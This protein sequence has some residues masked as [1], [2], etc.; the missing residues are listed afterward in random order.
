[1]FRMSNRPISEVR[2]LF[3]LLC[4]AAVSVIPAV[5]A[6]SEP[7]EIID[8]PTAD[9]VE[10]SHYNLGFRL[11]GGGGV[12]TRMDFGVFKPINLGMSWDINQLIGPG[13]ARV[14][15]R[16][17]A[18]FF[19][20]RVLSGGLMLP[21]VA[22]GYDGQGYGAFDT[23]GLTEKDKYQF[24]EKG[25]FA[26]CTREFLIPGLIA[27]FGGNIYDFN[28]ESVY[29]FAGASYSLEDRLVLLGEYDNIHSKALNR[30]NLGA[31][32]NITDTITLEVAGR[33]LFRGP[34]S[35]RI[36]VIK[37]KGKF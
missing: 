37:Y 22:V 6:S 32:F 23:P 20:A 28:G 24:R 2:C 26:V 10:Y 4:A 3:L 31:G 29:G 30:A 25:I 5:A 1:M 19:K 7:T 27:S 15:T 34:A 18:I 12:L 8:V 16:P 13:S 35:E 9:V 33:N 21:A 11:Y 14:D 36:A 17:P